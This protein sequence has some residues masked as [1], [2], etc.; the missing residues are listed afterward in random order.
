MPEDETL[1]Q[2][3]SDFFLIQVCWFNYT[4]HTIALTDLVAVFL[5]CVI[6][7]VELQRFSLNI[8]QPQSLPC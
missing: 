2:L 1:Q 5:G 3:A 4:T 7:V 8:P 6:Y